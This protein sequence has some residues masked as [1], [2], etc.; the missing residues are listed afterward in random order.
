MRSE[1]VEVARAGHVRHDTIVAGRYRRGDVRNGVV[2]H[3]EDDQRRV[4]ERRHVV[5]MDNGHL[6]AYAPRAVAKG[7]A[8]STGSHDAIFITAPVRS[9]PSRVPVRLSA[10]IRV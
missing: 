3:A 2:G 9:S 1:H 5:V 10:T 6:V 8:R 7:R 4:P